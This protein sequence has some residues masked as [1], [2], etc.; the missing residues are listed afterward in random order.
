MGCLRASQRLSTVATSFTCVICGAGFVRYSAEIARFGA[1]KYCTR[2]CQ[3]AARRLAAGPLAER[4][5]AKVRKA[6]GD[7]ACWTWAGASRG[8][9]YGVLQTGSRMDGTRGMALAHRVSWELHY[10]P[11]PEGLWVL[12]QCDRPSCVRPEHL[13]LGTP[14]DNTDDMWRKGRARAYGRSVVRMTAFEVL[15]VRHL[16]AFGAD[17]ETLT[18]LFPSVSQAQLRQ[19]MRAPSEHIE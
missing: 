11:I 17:M 19:A 12:H 6:D 15:A 13:F 18:G 16:L 5:W 2:A 14:Q 3:S 7:D 4:F 8:P 9:G 1:G 10:G